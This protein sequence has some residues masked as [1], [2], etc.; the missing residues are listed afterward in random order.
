MRSR[1]ADTDEV[2]HPADIHE[3]RGVGESQPQ[4]RQQA[5]AASDDLRVLTATC[6]GRHRVANRRGPDV[7]ELCRDHAAPPALLLADEIARH[8][9]SGVQG[10][11][12]S[13][14]PNDRSASMMALTTAGVDAI[15]PASPTPLT[16]SRLPAGDDV[17]AVRYD[18]RSAADGTR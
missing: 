15:V 5:L 9:R 18:G 6:Q 2:V 1:V 11:A 13:D 3:Q 8:T 7:V 14:T 10:I 4:Q 12:I 17:R 16:P